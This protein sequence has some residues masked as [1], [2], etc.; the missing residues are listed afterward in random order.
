MIAHLQRW[1]DAGVGIGLLF[2]VNRDVL[3]L[4]KAGCQVGLW[5]AC[6]GPGQSLK[7]DQLA[8]AAVRAFQCFTRYRLNVIVCFRQ[9]SA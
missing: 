3:R 8:A 5:T 7:Q 6:T 2:C 1:P 9:R 4:R